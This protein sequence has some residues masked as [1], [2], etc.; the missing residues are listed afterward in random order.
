MVTGDLGVPGGAALVS[1]EQE[2]DLEAA[3]IPKQEMGGKNALDQA[4]HQ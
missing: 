1:L 4:S 3:T 2:K